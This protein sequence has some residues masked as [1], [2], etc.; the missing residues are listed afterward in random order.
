MSKIN[1]IPSLTEEGWVISSKDILAYLLSYY[2]LSDAM[3]SIAYKGNIINLPETYYNHIN[4]P[5]EMASAVKADLERLLGSYFIATDV[6]TDVKEITPKHYA[7]LIYATVIDQDN[8]K[9]ELTKITE[10]NSAGIKNIISMSN[11]GDGVNYL[12]SI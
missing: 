8:I 4:D 10:I 5:M 12:N 3:Q 6:V 1:V 7:I 9:H 11:Y 2:I